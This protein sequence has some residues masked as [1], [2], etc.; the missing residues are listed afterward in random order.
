MLANAHVLLLACNKLCKCN[1]CTPPL[2][3]REIEGKKEATATPIFAVAAAN[4]LS[5]CRTSGRRRN[6]SERKPQATT[7]GGKGKGAR[8]RSSG[9][10]VSG[11][12]PVNKERA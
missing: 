7:Q 11:V 12:T 4:I 2:A 3:E 8:G 9:K 1:D 6:R 10:R 5:A